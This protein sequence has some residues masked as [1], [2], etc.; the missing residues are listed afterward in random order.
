MFTPLAKR[1][2]ALHIVPQ[3]DSRLQKP[4][5]H[6]TISCDR[7]TWRMKKVMTGPKKQFYKCWQTICSFD[8]VGS[9]C[10]G[11]MYYAR[12]GGENASMCKNVYNSHHIKVN[13]K[14][15]DD[16]V[17]GPPTRIRETMQFIRLQIK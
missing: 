14:S 1:L 6:P 12:I 10:V 17:C 11:K 8:M 2:H 5:F 7:I 3:I 9:F 16:R 13:L 4:I 15:R